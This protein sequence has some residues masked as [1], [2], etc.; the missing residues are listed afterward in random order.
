[1]LW[2]YVIDGAMRLPL[3]FF[4]SHLSI[5]SFLFIRLLIFLI[6]IFLV[7]LLYVKSTKKPIDKKI[8]FR[9]AMYVTLISSAVWLILTYLLGGLFVRIFGGL[10]EGILTAVLTFL[11]VYFIL[12]LGNRFAK[13]K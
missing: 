9:V 7:G 2:L 4:R 13:R 6:A 10:F 3:R 12:P 8:R 5:E 1:M 11:A